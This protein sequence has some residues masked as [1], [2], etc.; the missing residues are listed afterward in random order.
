MVILCLK[1]VMAK[2]LLIYVRFLTII[3]PPPAHQYNYD[4]YKNKRKE[5]ILNAP[6]YQYK[7]A[8]HFDDCPNDEIKLERES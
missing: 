5:S 6:H 7:F 2:L 4:R 8:H 1:A 3:C